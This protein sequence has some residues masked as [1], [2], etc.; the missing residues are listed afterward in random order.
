MNLQEK[1]Y[2]ILKQLEK[3][4]KTDINYVI[5]GSFWWIFGKV[6]SFLS[7]FLM[8]IFFSRFLSKEV[9]G[10]YQYVLST[11][12]IIGILSL[13][14]IGTAL[15]RAAA[16]GRE[17]TFFLCEKERIK[18]SFFTFLI[19]LSVSGWYFLHK[20]L[21]LGFSF[22]ISS[23]FSPLISIFSLYSSFLQ[24]KKKFDL[25]NI[26]FIL[27]NILAA[28]FIILITILKPKLVWIIFAYYFGFFITNFIFTLKIRKM[29]DLNTEEDKE[30]VSL[31][32]HLTIMTIPQYIAGQIDNVILW[33]IA[34][35]IEVAI[36]AFA[37]RLVE[38]ISEIFP[39][40]G[41]AFPKMAE[42][43]LKEIKKSIFEKFLKLF[44]FSIPLFG[45]YYFLCPYFFKIFFPNYLNSIFYSQILAITLLFTPFSFLATVF[46]ADGRK[47]ELYLLNLLPQILKIIL[48][49]ILIPLF[50]I[51]GGIYSILISQIFY[52][53]L[54][55]YFFKKF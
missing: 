42:K 40:S 32:K 30:A 21:E 10:A 43:N 7:S 49:F 5:K 16:K 35:P 55:L 29:I 31:G 38:R 18:F 9:Y 15:L 28:F 3:Y 39:F 8:L 50:K 25:Q 6:I 17:K 12:G 46:L 54:T 34:G 44:L 47:K 11:A 41:L 2:K 45:L 26:Y 52:S 33:Q 14:E 53:I 22:L 36:Y 27:N 20:N 23:I 24:G 4:T 37:L 48:F 51:W 19:L 1:S 13:S